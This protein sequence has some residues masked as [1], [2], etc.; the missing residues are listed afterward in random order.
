MYDMI[1]KDTVCE[2]CGAKK[3][4]SFNYCLH[5]G[6]K[7]TSTYSTSVPRKTKSETETS[8][9]KETPQVLKYCPSCGMKIIKEDVY[10]IECGAKNPTLVQNTKTTTTNQTTNN[11]ENSAL[12]TILLILSILNS[13][14]FMPLSG[15][16]ALVSF[17]VMMATSSGLMVFLVSG[18]Y[19][20]ASIAILVKS[21]KM[22]SKK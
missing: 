4:Q 19:F 13:I 22:N 10:C 6:T 3:S 15:I 7:F 17:F 14:S 21:I 11:N 16:V 1:G 18:S 12:W 2:N 9:I 20:I 8:E 5:C